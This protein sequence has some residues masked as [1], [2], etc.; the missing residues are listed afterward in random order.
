VTLAHA[1][2]RVNLMGDYAD[3]GGCHDR[4]STLNREFP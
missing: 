4:M 2:C 1:R 3:Y